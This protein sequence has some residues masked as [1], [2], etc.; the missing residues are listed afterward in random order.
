MCA[1]EATS[2]EALT[3]R[4][5]RLMHWLEIIQEEINELECNDKTIRRIILD[6][7]WSIVKRFQVDIR[8][9]DLE[10]ENI[11][12]DEYEKSRVAKKEKIE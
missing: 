1:S 11:R 7:H 2:S 5:G 8:D 4:R 6:T 12:I 3:E 10:L 9:I